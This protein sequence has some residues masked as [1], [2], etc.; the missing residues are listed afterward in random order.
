VC[1]VLKTWSTTSELE[2]S[3]VTRIYIYIYTGELTGN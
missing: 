3:H 2:P 1:T